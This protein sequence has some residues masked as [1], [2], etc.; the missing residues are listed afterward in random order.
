V[1]TD[2]QGYAGEAMVRSM[3]DTHSTLATL[4]EN[5]RGFSWEDRV[6]CAMRAALP[7]FRLE[8]AAEQPAVSVRAAQPHEEQRTVD[9]WRGVKEPAWQCGPGPS[10]GTSAGSRFDVSL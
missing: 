9:R 1:L 2:W 3:G 8:V 7:D 5:Y 10:G 4:A 6:R